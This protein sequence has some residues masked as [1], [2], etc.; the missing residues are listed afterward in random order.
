MPTDYLDP[1]FEPTVGPTF[2]E[3]LVIGIIRAHPVKGLTQEERI[4]KAMV[5]LT[6][7]FSRETKETP[8]QAALLK[9]AELWC[10]ERALHSMAADVARQDDPPKD[11]P[12]P[13]FSDVS[14]LARVATPGMLRATQDRSADA[15]WRSRI[16][17]L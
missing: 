17:V 15:R 13:N 6:G 10:R 12:P 5:A 7:K 9:M 4:R 1:Y 3:K 8:D 16:G 2:L 11:T 14:E